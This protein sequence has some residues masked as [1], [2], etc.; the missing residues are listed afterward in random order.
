MQNQ[1]IYRYYSPVTEGPA[2]LEG[3]DLGNGRV[4]FTFQPPPNTAVANYTLFRCPNI[5]CQVRLQMAAQDGRD[6]GNVKS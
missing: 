1:C 2:N 6:W 5:N 4:N 3:E